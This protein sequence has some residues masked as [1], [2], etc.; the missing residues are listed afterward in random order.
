MPANLTPEY[1]AAD[2]KFKAAVTPQEKLA[3]LEEM[4][5]TIPKHKGT[6]KMQADIKRRI[7]RLRAEAQRQRR[8]ARGKPFYH[9]DREGA[10]QL[11]LAG[12]PNTGKSALLA[13]LTNAAPEVAEYPFTTRVPLPGMMI[14]ENVQ[15]QLVD[16]PP[17]TADLTEGWLYALIRTAD[18]VLLVADLASDDL[19]EQTDQ[20]L[21]LLARANIHL[22]PPPAP[23]HQKPALV[24]ANKLDAS[25][26][27]DRLALLREFLG[28]R[29]P[30]LAVSAG[31]GTGL[32]ALREAAFRLLGVI[33]VYSK[34]PGRKADLSAPFILPAG[35]TV[36]DAAEAIHKDLRDSLRYARLWRRQGAQGQMVGR[37]HV[38]AD[39]DVIEI[40]A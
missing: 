20:V 7:A 6:E 26:A 25:G 23:P 32:E 29:L 2:R 5:A 39:G 38:L 11:V 17:I 9:V 22:S 12:A 4:L 18:G 14:Y 35:A 34:P 37:D 15:I 30:V 24:I 36:L 16:L 21:T 40:H 28:S 33:R 10:G 27:G 3:A 19:L 31:M 1:L 13:A 8:A